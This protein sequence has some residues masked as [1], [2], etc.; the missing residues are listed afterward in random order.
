MSKRTVWAFIFIATVYLISLSVRILFPAVEKEHKY[1]NAELIEW[2]DVVIEFRYL[3]IGRD[4]EEPKLIIFPDPFNGLESLEP[5]ANRLSDNWQVFIPIFPTH[6]IEGNQLSHSSTSRAEMVSVWLDKH[7]FESIHLAGQGFGNSSAIEFIGSDN[8]NNILSYT[9]LSAVGVQEF[10]FL[11]YHLLNKPIYSFL[12]PLGYLVEY[13]LPIAAWNKQ[14]TV[15]LQGARYMNELDQRGYR[16]VLSSLD[17]PVL[18]LHGKEDRHVSAETAR[19]HHRIIPQSELKLFSGGRYSI[20]EYKDKWAN[21][22]SSFLR[23]AENGNAMTRAEAPPE[24]IELAERDFQFGNVPPVYGWGLI[25][26]LVLLSCV[27]LV[28][29]DLGCIGGGLLVAGGVIPMWIAFLTIYLGILIADT[30]IYWMGR[31][32]GRPVIYKAPFRWFVSKKDIDRTSEMFKTNGFKII[33]ASRF[34]PGTRFPTYF[35][36]GLLKTNFNMFLLYFII[37]I[38]IW[39]PLLLWVS[40]FT[41]QQMLVYLQIYQEYALHIFIGLVVG[42]Y[43]L[44]KLALPLATKKGRKELAVRI[45]RLK[46]RLISE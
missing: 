4:D 21:S 3:K 44:F 7:E 38:S 45:I 2:K 24:R 43:I 13:A 5:L 9:M 12:Y 27:T 36:A 20:S 28:S 18:I 34:L 41:G 42:L 8:L 29:E 11:G 40:I 25:L 1:E 32:L 37:A 6:S 16:D 39:A 30:G 14:S 35:T 10:Q 33:F 22:F 31:Q 15:N 19:E 17:I 26:I 46:Q 23:S